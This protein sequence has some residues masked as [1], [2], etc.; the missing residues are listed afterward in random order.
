MPTG[1]IVYAFSGTLRVVPFDLRRLEVTGGPV[2]VIEGV[3]RG[4]GEGTGIAHFSYRATDRSFMFLVRR[5]QSG[6]D[7]ALIDREGHVEPLNLQPGVQRSARVAQRQT[8]GL[9]SR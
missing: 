1:H 4:L 5:P 9:S 2:P 8:G 7:L 3:R 6:S